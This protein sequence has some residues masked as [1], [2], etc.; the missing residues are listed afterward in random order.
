MVS[1]CANPSCDACFKY[2]REGRLFRFPAANPATRIRANSV[3]IEFWWLCPRCCSSMTLVEDR[4]QGV[5][6]VPLSRGLESSLVQ[7]F[8]HAG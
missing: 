7:K 2:L 1:R 5:K 4:T 8:D 6:L 3:V